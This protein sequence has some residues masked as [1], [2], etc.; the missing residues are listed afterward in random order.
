MAIGAIPIVDRR[1]RYVGVSKL[2]ELNSSKL[3]ETEDTLVIQENDSPIAVL[4]SYE[5]Y[6]ILQ[7][8]L[9]SVL[10][11]LEVVLDET[12]RTGLMAGLADLKAGRIR[13]LADIEA[14][15]DR[16]KKPEEV[17]A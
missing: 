11:T 6:L 10:N 2:R 8:Q 14:E 9:F 7:E 13:S 17:N 4:L 5:N 1:V 12:E 15:A 3:K 16:R